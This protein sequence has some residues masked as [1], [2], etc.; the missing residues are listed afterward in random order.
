[1]E[2]NFFQQIASL[3]TTANIR[4]TIQSLPDKTMVVSILAVQEELADKAVNKI[5][6]LLLK[7]SAEKIDAAFFGTI[8]EP[9]KKT[10][11]LITNLL[12]YQNSVEKAKGESR[13]QKDKEASD[14]KVRDARKPKYDEQM[15]KVAE[16]EAK[17]LYGQAIAQMPDPKLFPEFA[18][19]IKTKL[20][21]LRGSNGTLSLFTEGPIVENESPTDGGDTTVPDPFH[22]DDPEEEND[23]PEDDDDPEEEEPEE[24]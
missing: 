6:S 9:V 18:E 14:K 8:S 21:S 20:T 23:Q 17:K 11:E 22:A 5:P 4:I 24:Y 19:E 13:I 10:D 15:K 3:N 2:T 7:G 1:M 16:L 12:N